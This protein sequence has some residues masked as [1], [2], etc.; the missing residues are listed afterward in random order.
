MEQSDILGIEP[1]PKLI[2]RLVPPMMLVFFVQAMYN[3]MDSMFIARYDESGLT[4]LSIIFPLQLILL[5]IA[6]GTGS[7]INVIAARLLGEG[8]KSAA[9][10]T[11]FHGFILGIINWI[12]TT[13]ICL[14]ILVPYFKISTSDALVIDAG[15]SYGKIIIILSFGLYIESN[16]TKILQATGNMKIP[17]L[18][19]SSGA[20]CNIIFD[21]LLI[22]GKAGFPEM[23]I[24][25]AATATVAGQIL[26]MI[27]S[28]I[29]VLKNKCLKLRPY[30]IKIKLFIKIYKAAMPNIIMQSLYTVYIFGLNL[31]LG[32]F[33]SAAVTV[34]GIY[35]KLQSFFFIPLF[36]MEQAILPIISYNHGMHNFRRIRAALKYSCLISVICMGAAAVAFILI[37][38]NLIN[39][40]S[41]NQ[42]ILSIG[43][44]A[45][46]IIGLS[47]IPAA[48]TLLLPVFFQ[49]L[50]KNFE[51]IFTTVLRQIILFVP[52]AWL[53]SKFGLDFVWLT[54]PCTETITLLGGV[55]LLF[56]DSFFFDNVSRN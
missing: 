16:C 6:T 41:Q 9:E 26:A 36:G 47:F 19:Q 28:F 22:F 55:I 10:K 30:K 2:F 35:Y 39:I 44:T 49:G 5:A 51:S 45:F 32:T 42:E 13:L 3:I 27:I 21:Y 11:A 1:I 38:T 48:V 8:N 37:P 24:S 17:M 46:P 40:F 34:L 4:A 53:F 14:I 20:V 56:K 15:V 54:F 43:K 7:G 29:G 31:I 52:L 25:G 18:A 33:S 50:S 23:G 12:A